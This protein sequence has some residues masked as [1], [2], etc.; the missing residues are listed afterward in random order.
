MQFAQVRALRKTIALCLDSMRGNL[1]SLAS[2]RFATCVVLNAGQWALDGRRRIPT[3]GELRRRVTSLTEEMLAGSVDFA[4]ALDD[5][6]GNLYA[7]LLR[8]LDAENIHHD[9]LVKAQGL[10]HLVVT[11]PP[12][13]GIH[14][15]YHR[16]QIDG[17]KESDAPYWIAKCLDGSGATHYNFADRKLAA[18]D[19]Y[20]TKAGK[21]FTSVRRVMRPGAIMAQLV[22]FPEPERHLRR[23][24]SVMEGAGFKELRARHSRRIWRTVPSRRWHATSKGHLSSSKEI[25][26]LHIVE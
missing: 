25:V 18:E 5:L 10:A 6:R 15:L 4:G 14:M 3:A 20:Y 12:Y 1:S 13:P 7:P 21:V 24:L 11:S 23:Y 17:R 22:A 16:W 19:R 26:L 9:A 8:Q 2:E